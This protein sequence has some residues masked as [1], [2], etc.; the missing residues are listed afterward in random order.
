[1]KFVNSYS[2]V[3]KDVTPTQVWAIWSDV[4]N[5]HIWDS[6]TQWAKLLG[7][8]KVG[9]TFIFKPKG[10]PKLKMQITECTYN[11]SFT[12]CF[13]L[14]FAKLY[15]VH[16]VEETQQGLLITTTIKMEGTLKWVWQKLLADKIIATLPEQTE[17]LIKAARNIRTV[18]SNP[19]L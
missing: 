16:E 9:S 11:K 8:F 4:D 19:I 10:G 5:R 6:D 1:M 15:G 3:V 2:V 13:K 18:V 7:E 12:D 17:L 14:P